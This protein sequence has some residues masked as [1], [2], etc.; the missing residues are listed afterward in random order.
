MD[1]DG[2]GLPFLKGQQP[3]AGAKGVSQ[4]REIAKACHAADTPFV[5]KGIMTERGAEKAMKAGVDGIVVS[6]HGGRVQD[7]VE[8]TATVLPEISRA[9]GDDLVVLVD[10]GI[11]SGVD[12]F[13]A[14]ALGANAV[15]MCRPFVVAMYGGGEQGVMDLL[16]QL[17]GELADTMEMC[18][19][20][21]VSDITDD[22]VSW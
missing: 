16:A 15:L 1:I 17:Q 4:L 18:G 9:V 19:A 22:L 5:L 6:N 2:A 3:P 7:G 21:T 14:L 13:R 20:E 11:R 8:A 12:V 10:G